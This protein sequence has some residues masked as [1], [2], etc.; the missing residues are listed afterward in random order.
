[1]SNTTTKIRKLDTFTIG[2]CTLA[3]TYNHQY[4]IVPENGGYI[5]EIFDRDEDREFRK[6][7]AQTVGF[8]TKKAALAYA[9]EFENA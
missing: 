2:G 8:K 6:V 9:T 7:P 5:L 3:I 4:V 1:M